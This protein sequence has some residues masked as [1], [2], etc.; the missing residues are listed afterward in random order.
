MNRE[1]WLDGFNFFHHWESTRGLLRPDSGLDIVRAI[2]RSLRILSRHLGR[3]C[4]HTVVYLDGGL[5]RHET[6]AAGLRVRYCGPGRKADDR[7]VEDLADLRESA[8]LITAVSNDRELK[9][10]LRAHGAACL[11][12]GEFLSV[13]E[14][15]AAPAKP[16]KGKRPGTRPGSPGEAAEVMR[17]KTR[18]LSASEVRAWLEYF[19]EAEEDEN[20]APH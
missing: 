7:L 9:A 5:S 4:G 14:G 10:N 2:E 18:T 1:F 15:K 3:K 12:V 13:V 6:R 8:R 16:A 17:Q 11:G 19:G 20:N